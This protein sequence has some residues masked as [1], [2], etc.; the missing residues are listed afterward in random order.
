MLRG[1]F[2]TKIDEKGRLKIPA[3]FR[4][5]IG[6]KYGEALYVTSV[7]GASVVFTQCLFGLALKKSLQKYRQLTPP[8]C[9]SSIV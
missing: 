5:L 7:T 6:E 3:A 9:V 8:V 2:Y 4:S 1:N